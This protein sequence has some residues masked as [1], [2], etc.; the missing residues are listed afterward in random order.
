VE[1]PQLVVERSGSDLVIRW[2]SKAGRL[3]N[4]RSETDPSN[5]EPVSWPIFG[6]HEDLEATPPENTLVFPLPADPERF[7][8]IEEFPA[9]PESVYSDNFEGG[10]GAWTTGGDPGLDPFTNWE[11]GSPTVVGPAAANSGVNCFGT[12]LSA[13]YAEDA[14]IWLRSP[15]INLT[16]AAGATLNFSHYVDIEETF[17]FGQIRLLDADAANAELAILQTAIDGNNPTGWQSFSKSLPGAALG[18]NVVIE[19]R[20]D[21]DDFVNQAG[22]YIDDVVVT[23]VP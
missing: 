23:V 5:G 10:Q 9:P 18:K 4:L 15:A 2:E 6:G 21:S 13:D 19:F 14:D 7:F 12:N 3:Y 1:K 8:V 22:W 11:F 16:A 20:F 17:D